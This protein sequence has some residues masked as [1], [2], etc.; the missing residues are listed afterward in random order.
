[1]LPATAPRKDL[2]VLHRDGNLQYPYELL[3]DHKIVVDKDCTVFVAGRGGIISSANTELRGFETDWGSIPSWFGLKKLLE[4]QQFIPAANYSAADHNLRIWLYGELPSGHIYL[5]GYIVDPR[6]EFYLLHDWFYAV[7]VTTR[8]YADEKLR[9]QLKTHS[10][11][12]AKIVYRAVRLFGAWAWKDTPM[13]E[14]RQDRE[15]SRQARIRYLNEE[16]V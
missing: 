16:I 6:A 12:E 10:P 15:L 5:K 14:I 9:D 1:M 7:Q 11:L 8:E 13:K 2:H 4:P 3:L